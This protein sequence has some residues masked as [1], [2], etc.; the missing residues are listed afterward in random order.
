MAEAPRHMAEYLARTRIDIA[1]AEENARLIRELAIDCDFRPTG[2]Y[3]AVHDT[4]HFPEAEDAARALREAGATAEVIE[5]DAAAARFG[6]GFYRTLQPGK[7]SKGLV[8][9]MPEPVELHE[10][11]PALDLQPLAGGGALV[12]I[13]GGE[14]R[15]R[16]VIL[17]L[18][19]LLPRFGFK[20]FHVVPLVLTASLTRPLT[21]E[22]D[23]Q[24]GNP[25]PWAALCP[26]KGGTTARLTA[27]RRILIRNTLES[28]AS[29]IDTAGVVARR[30]THVLGLRRRFPWMGEADIAYSWAGTMA[31]S[32]GHRCV[33]EQAALGLFLA[34]ACNGT[35]VSRMSMLGRLLV[36]YATGDQNDLLSTTLALAKP[37]PVP[38]DPFL[39]VGLSMRFAM[40]ERR[41][42]SE[43]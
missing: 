8:D 10:D 23:A 17:G 21:P 6:S 3:Y 33:F 28:G 31:G 14:I 38:P 4:A 36:Q 26:I 30:K 42:A 1:G 12:R 13:P 35:G 25:E 11:T 37:G 39:R 27:D 24:I 9:T 34:A 20:R 19:G 41:A 18:N 7:F 2:Y 15:A 43:K 5:D 29:G 16:R 22:E 32:R 40:D